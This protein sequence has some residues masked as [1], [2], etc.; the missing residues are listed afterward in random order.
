MKNARNKQ[1]TK[2]PKN[3]RTRVFTLANELCYLQSYYPPP[4]CATTAKRTRI[5]TNLRAT[6]NKDRF[7]NMTKW[8]NF[9]TPLILII[10]EMSITVVA[11]NWYCV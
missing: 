11:L 1:K 2:I 8:A 4:K 7:F 3:P 10:I 9:A 6:R 5:V